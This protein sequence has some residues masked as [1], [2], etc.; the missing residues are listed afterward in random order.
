[1]K[2]TVIFLGLVIV[3]LGV[4]GLVL[5]QG[6]KKEEGKKVTYNKLTPEEERVIVH[7]GTEM[8]FTGKYTDHK[9]KGT[10][11]CKRCGAELYRSE[12]KFDSHCGWPSFDDAIPGAVKQ[13]RDTDGM[14]TEILCQNCGGHLGHVFTG[15]GFTSKDIRFCVNSISM[16]FIPAGSGSN[17][18][19]G[20]SGTQTQKAYFAGGCFWGTEHYLKDAKGVTDVRVGY[21]GG[22]TKNPTYKQ[23]CSGT[24]GHI[25]A[26]EVTF[27]PTKTTYEEIA[28]LFFEI[29]DPAQV[30]RQGPDIGEQYKSVVFYADQEQK[31]AAE[32]LIGILKSKGIPVAT[33]LRPA[34]EFWVAEDYHQ[35]Y[36]AKTGKEPYCH[37][38]VKRF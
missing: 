36:Y 4:F 24:T 26:N 7:K 2:T 13:V 3:V 38:R 12:D 6:K 25:E 17:K 1:M 18:T 19:N 5:S 20:K 16:N 32:K 29:H 27:D 22:R 23:V 14:R 34:S 15:E 8:A 31:K 35:D 11:T 21:M 37:S 30:N 33:E 10:Y 9:E 28:R